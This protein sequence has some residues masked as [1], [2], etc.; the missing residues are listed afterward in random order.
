MQRLAGPT[1]FSRILKGPDKPPGASA[2]RAREKGRLVPSPNPLPLETDSPFQLDASRSRG[3]Q[4]LAEFRIVHVRSQPRQVGVVERV[5][6]V[7]AHLQV[8]AL[9]QEA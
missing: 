8:G 7:R 3:A 6:H 5:E 9:S 1:G 2:G 4:K